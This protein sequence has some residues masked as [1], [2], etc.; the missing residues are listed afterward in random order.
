MSGMETAMSREDEVKKYLDQHNII[1]VLND[2]T[3]ALVFYR[4]EDPRLF[5]IGELTKM[6]E[7]KSSN[8]KIPRLLNPSNAKAIFDTLDP[9]GRGYITAVQYEETMLQLGIKEFKPPSH[10]DNAQITKEL[11]LDQF[12]PN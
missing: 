1:N 2:L 5:L 9:T 12:K 10:Y 11:F 4:P 7:T 8:I 6:R 3:S